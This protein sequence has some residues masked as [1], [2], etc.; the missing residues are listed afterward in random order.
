VCGGHTYTHYDT[1]PYYRSGPEQSVLG[2]SIT[3]HLQNWIKQNEKGKQKRKTELGTNKVRG[4][5]DPFLTP[6]P[7]NI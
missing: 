3:T 2:Y 6:S 7:I 5:R 1:H 4:P